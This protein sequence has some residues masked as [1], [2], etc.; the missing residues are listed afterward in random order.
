LYLL[1]TIAETQQI[2]RE[3]HRNRGK[4]RKKAEEHERKG[5]KTGKQEE[6]AATLSDLYPSTV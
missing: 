5:E 6:N 1:I 3:K 4:K 2:L